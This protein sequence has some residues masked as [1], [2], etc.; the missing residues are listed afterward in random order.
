MNSRYRNVICVFLF[1]SFLLNINAQ[2]KKIA[3]TVS[4]ST[5]PL[6]G[7][8]VILKGTMNGTETDFEG[9]Y[10][11]NA[12]QGDVLVFSFVG[13]K[14]VE[15]AVGTQTTINVLLEDDNDMLEEIVVVGYGSVAKKD[16][17][18]AISTIGIEQLED[19]PVAS[20]TQALQ[21]A[22]SGLQIV[23]TGGRTGD[24]TQISIRGNGSLSA[25]NNALYVIDGVPQ[26]DMTG[27]SPE[28]I[29]SISVLKD[30]ASTAIYGSRASNGV[31]LIQTKRGSY[32]KGI[33]VSLNTSYGIQNIVKRPSL[34]N[35]TQY[36]HISDVARV[37]YENDIAAGI[38]AGP[39]DPN[40][41]TPLPTSNY[42][43]D[44]L[45]LVLKENAA[46]KRHQFSISGGGEN[47]R[48][49]LSASL[50]DQEGVIKEDTYKIARVKLNME[51]KM[52][53]YIKFG[54]NSNFAFSEATP[55]VDDNN[56][57][58]PYTKAL[59]ARPDVSPY[60]ADGK[61]AEYTFRNPLYAFERQLTSKWQNLGGTFY[62]DVK[63]V[64]SVVWHSAYSGNIRS[65]RYNRY[66]A[67]NTR[68]GL[69]GD[70]VPTGYGYYSTDNNRDYLIE[71]TVTFRDSF[72]NDKLNVNLLGGHSFQKWEY[73]DSFVEGEGFP[74][75]DLKWLTSAG[76]INRGRSYYKAMALESYFTRLQLSWDAKYHLMLSTRYD[77]SSK[78]TK[79][80]R[81]GNF[82]AVSAGWTVSNEDFFNV[83]A[84]N[85]LKIRGSFGYNGNQSGISYASGQNLI[86][87]GENYD[88]SPGLASTSIFN[89]N[90]IW[91][92]AED[93]N[94]GF[95][96]T[97]FNKIDINFD[98]YQKETQDLLSRIN[99]PQESGF[100]TMLANVGKI[101]NKGFEVNVNARIIEKED[102][103]W[104]FGGNFSYNKNEVL[105]VGSETGQ[106]T[107]GFVSV[108]K[109][110]NSLGSFF[111]LEAA[112]IANE[113]YTYKD[114]D[115]NDGYTV[116]AGDMIYVDQNQD[117]QINDDD[118][119]VFEGGIAPIYGGF[120]TRIDYKGFDLGISG[121]YSIGKKVY[122]LFKRDL[123]NGGA[124]GAPSYSN[125][126]ITEMLD[127][128][129]PENPN[130]A[131]P[132]P[133]LASTISS[134]NTRESTRFLENADYLRISNI[135][136]GYSFNFLKDNPKMNFIK[137][138]RIYAQLVNPFTFTSYSGADPETS[139]VDQTEENSQDRSDGSKI[140]AGVD[141]GGI[142]N[143]KSFSVGL[144]VKF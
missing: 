15:K 32:G 133:H 105:K 18:G 6:P 67:P 71:N 40:S 131:N 65:N 39:K 94:V 59:E 87:S 99:V 92:K 97:L 103:R 28:D 38:L 96:M 60:T 98:Y 74:S 5:G 91:E 144:N 135:T 46:V 3:G 106:Y 102:F 24:A 73:E 66:D 95:D 30:A 104:S 33:Q 118:K 100:R 44:W 8:N 142:P 112:G 1:F 63:P 115:G 25:S 55:I 81:W 93:F 62:F 21:G 113:S 64:E 70:G 110:G 80:N 11:I 37:N 7:V 136:L 129:T 22:T 36:K 48:A 137:S 51:Q 124:V 111:I 101:S 31:V 134:W 123:L 122:A 138:L 116:A 140:E 119:K 52:N 49:Y 56:S 143:I 69:N 114:K 141:L 29:K 126:M 58:Q 50:F 77:G 35:S 89:P 125:N 84:I 121:Q 13:M 78:F 47:T 68:R 117:G 53:D 86:G 19:K 14:T 120:N 61:I 34:L 26:E 45:S 130:A 17:T 16:L 54:I 76:E 41:L 10:L 2:Q 23:S 132:R 4:D 9:N 83:S 42:D 88:Q 27:I 128:W 107:T 127:Y 139:Y 109:E 108:V 75:S 72:F 82:P 79:D 57:Y 12:K 85:S 90:L 20:V 43:V